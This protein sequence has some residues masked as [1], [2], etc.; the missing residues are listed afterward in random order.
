MKQKQR[1]AAGLCGLFL[2]V[3]LCFGCSAPMLPPPS[4]ETLLSYETKPFLCTFTV[5]EPDGYSAEA[6]LRRSED[7]DT[8]TVTGEY[9]SRTVYRFAGGEVFLFC[10]GSETEDALSVPVTLSPAVCGTE[11]GIARGAGMWR[12]LFSLAVSPE[13]SVSRTEGGVSLLSGGDTFLFSEDG[14]PAEFVRADG[15]RICVSSF[16]YTEK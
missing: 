4:A 7:G 8:L 9:G 12:S 15:S 5:T 3:W 14:V 13:M 11:C 2:P 1:T 16:C 10:T 6:E